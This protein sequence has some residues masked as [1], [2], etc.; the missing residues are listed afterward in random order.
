MWSKIEKE[1]LEKQKEQQEKQKAKERK[2]LFGDV[3][4]PT[5]EERYDL[6]EL[7][8]ITD[9]NQFQESEKRLSERKKRKILYLKIF[10]PVRQKTV[11]KVKVRITR[12]QLKLTIL[13][14]KN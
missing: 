8:D 5:F 12:I 4:K 10:S 11:L 13:K 14:L 6:T 1:M 2:K 9:Y 3:F 7:E